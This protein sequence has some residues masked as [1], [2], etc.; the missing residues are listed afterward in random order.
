M[1]NQYK[2]LFFGIGMLLIPNVSFSQCVA[3]TDC[4]TLGYT[5]NSCPDGKGIK[6]PFGNKWACM[7]TCSSK[8][9]IKKRAV[10]EECRPFKYGNASYYSVVC[11]ICF[12][13]CSGI[14]GQ[15]YER[16]CSEQTGPGS[17]GT[18]GFSS[19]EQAVA[20]LPRYEGRIQSDNCVN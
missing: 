1:T 20:A 13:I 11:R 15:C 17:F 3:T 4:A 6:C 12:Y 16:S 5:K 10:L 14:D 18:S 7:E 19:I 9:T 2:F 8:C